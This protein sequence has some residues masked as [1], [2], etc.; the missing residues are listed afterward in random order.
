MKKLSKR[1]KAIRDMIPSRTNILWDTCCDHGQLGKS[2]LETNTQI[3]FVDCVPHIIQTIENELKDSNY[4]NYSCFAQDL[5]DIKLRNDLD[6]TVVIAGVGGWTAIEGIKS[7][8][9]R[10]NPL[11]PVF[12]VS[13]QKNMDH[14]TQFMDEQNFTKLVTRLVEDRGKEYT[15]FKYQQDI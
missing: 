10:Y 4:K 3:N 12:I 15:I 9:S 14:F 8:L 2:F 1:L 11:K 7:I 5:K 6:E 13:V